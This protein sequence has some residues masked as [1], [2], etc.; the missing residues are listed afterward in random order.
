VPAEAARLFDWVHEIKHDRYMP[1]VC[2][3]G[4]TVR[5]CGY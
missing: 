2:R 5:P 4:D 3:A 1:Q